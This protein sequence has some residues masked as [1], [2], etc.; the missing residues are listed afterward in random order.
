[1][2]SVVF[3]ADENSRMHVAQN[4]VPVN[5]GTETARADLFQ[6]HQIV[7]RNPAKQLEILLGYTSWTPEV[8]RTWFRQNVHIHGH[9]SYP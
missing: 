8:G 5:I 2:H 3:L 9:Q 6:A 4:A 1:M 7:K